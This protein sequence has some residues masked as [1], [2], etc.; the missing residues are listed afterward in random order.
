MNENGELFTKF[1][2]VNQCAIDNVDNLPDKIIYKA[3]SA[4]PDNNIENQMYQSVLTRNLNGIYIN[5]TVLRGA[6]VGGFD[7]PSAYRYD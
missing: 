2:T 4:S 1:C 7:S 5:I 3:T 6:S